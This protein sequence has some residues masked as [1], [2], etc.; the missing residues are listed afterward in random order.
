M[1]FLASL[2]TKNHCGEHLRLG[3][4]WTSSFKTKFITTLTL[5]FWVSRASTL[6][7]LAMKLFLTAK[8]KFIQFTWYRWMETSQKP[9]ANPQWSSLIQQ[10]ESL[11]KRGIVSS[12][13]STS[14]Y[15][16][17]WNERIWVLIIYQLYHLNFHLLGPKLHLNPDK[18]GLE[19]ISKVCSRLKE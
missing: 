8:A 3:W 6:I 15:G 19:Y 11:S 14:R 12:T 18:C 16:G 4:D 7:L 17:L 2:W 9:R 13:L 10:E 5:G 1:D